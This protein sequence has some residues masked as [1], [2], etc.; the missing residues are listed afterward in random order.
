MPLPKPQIPHS[1]L[2]PSSSD[3]LLAA[4]ALTILRSHPYHLNT[5]SSDFTPEATSCLLLKSQQ[6]KALTLTLVNWAKPHHFFNPLNKCLAL[7]ILTKFKLFK[8]AQALA[9]D[10]AVQTPDDSGSFVFQCLKDTYHMCDSSSAVFDL[11]VK[12]YSH[13]NFTDKA[14]NIVNLAKVD[15]FMPGVLSYNAIIDSLIRCRKPTRLAE[16]V[17]KEMIAN[18]ISLNVF[19]YN[20]FIRGFCAAGNLD[21]GLK[22]FNEMEKNGCSPN[23]VTYNTVLDGYCKLK[24]VDDAFALLKGMVLKGLEP[25]LITFNVVIN[26][27]CR[28]GRMKESSE[29][30]A[31]M[32]RRGYVPDEVTYN[33]LV[34][35]HCKEGKFHEALVLHS[36]MVSNGLT[37]NVMTYTSLIN[38]MCQ[39]GNMNR[40]VQFFDQMHVRGLYPN[41]RTYTTLINGFARKGFLDEAYRV[42]NEMTSSG[43]VPS[44]V[45]YNAL[46]NGHCVLGRMD[47]AIGLLQ[48]MVGKGLG[49][50]VYSYSTIISGFSRNRELGKAF[51]MKSE[52][53]EKG[54]SPDLV[55]YSTLIQGLCEEG[56]LTEACEL[57][58][59]M[60]NRRLQPDEFIYTTLIHAYCKEGNLVKAL[61]LHDEMIEKGHL[62]DAV[63]YSV[64]I[65]GLDKQARTKEA[66]RL[67]LKLFYD[68]SI[69]SEITYSTL[70]ENSCNIE[71][72]GVLALMKGFCMKGLMDEADRVFESVIKKNH[73][74]NEDVYNVI[75]HGHCR[76]GNVHKAYGLYKEMVRCGFTPHTLTI[77]ALVKALYTQ[78]MNEQLNEVIGNILRSCKLSYAEL[79]KVQVEINQREGNMDGV[80]RVLAEMAKDGIIPS[81]SSGNARG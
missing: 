15:G 2:S 77:L 72:K 28:E 58:Q 59:E 56:S 69:P 17:Y 14:L 64:L 80:F 38:G 61:Q 19:S 57:F 13:L 42:L 21:M 75:I 12:S 35:G 10:L 33:T 51:Q 22:F 73:S 68:E 37:P 32:N 40:A 78:G 66:K 8:C 11:V 30:V 60:M 53:V 41:A 18:G 16:Q 44:I 65:N 54:I 27:L 7:H 76:G 24:R 23:V 71:F 52:M 70:I 31:E 74:P 43:F 4:K 36:E 34:N 9:Q 67:L 55:T 49:P 1:I 6:D 45:T 81:G 79:S 46:I 5:I 20:I 48:D 63:T 39:A 47:E 3:I 25:N 26:G 50:D 62:P 29:I